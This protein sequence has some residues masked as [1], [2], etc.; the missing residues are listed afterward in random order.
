MVS[1][2]DCLK[3]GAEILKDTDAPRLEAEILLCH[4]LQKD[5]LYAAV[6]KDE[7]LSE[8]KSNEFLAMCQRRAAGEPSAYITGTKEFMSLEF[9]VNGSVLIPRP[10]TELAVELVCEKYKNQNVNIIDICTG[11]GAIACSLAHFMPDA[12]IWATD[13]SDDA[14]RIAQRN[15]QKL[16]VSQR[17]NFVRA[18]A[19]KKMNFEERFDIAVSNPPYIESS[20]VD[21]LETT[22]KDYE[23]RL[24]LDGGAD[25]LIFYRK[26]VDNI[27]SILRP[28]GELIFEIGFNQ[29]QSLTKIMSPLFDSVNIIKDLAGLDRIACGQLRYDSK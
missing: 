5:R 12:H 3:I 18:D 19:L 16:G 7:H 10:E 2:A 27:K 9:E 15:A 14:L 28:G 24:A 20:V 11:S 26:I 23:P 6:H 1:I 13:I 8:K 4:I 21:S 17:V 22:V 25:G 29:G